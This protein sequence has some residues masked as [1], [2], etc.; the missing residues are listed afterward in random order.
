MNRNFI[1]ADKIVV[2]GQAEHCFLFRKQVKTSLHRSLAETLFSDYRRPEF[3]LEPAGQ[4]FRS[5]SAPFIYQ[6]NHFQVLISAAAKRWQERW[7]KLF[8][9]RW[10]KI[11]F[12]A[13][14]INRR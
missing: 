14:E 4:N 6:N 8:N 9:K 3:L 5:A 10:F 2:G 13:L 12:P 11:A 7:Q 1:P